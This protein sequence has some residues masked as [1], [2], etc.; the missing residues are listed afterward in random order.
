MNVAVSNSLAIVP[1]AT[2]IVFH[3]HDNTVLIALRPPHVPF[4]GLWEFPGGKVEPGETTQMAL[5]RELAEE[6]G[7]QVITAVPW[8]CVEQMYPTRCVRLTVWQVHAFSGVA[9]GCEGQTV[10]WI[11]P[12]MLYRY[13]FPAA[14]DVIIRALVSETVAAG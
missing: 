2:G 6:V 11:S 12:T 3:P 1:V 8:L 7:I 14:N 10:R 4:P 13:K 5:Q 9:S